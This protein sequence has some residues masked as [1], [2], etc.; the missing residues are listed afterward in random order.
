M[1]VLPGMA[2]FFSGDPLAS[3]EYA[4]QARYRTKLAGNPSYHFE[5]T[6]Y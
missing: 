5:A 1:L 4:I 2:A 6:R 3:S